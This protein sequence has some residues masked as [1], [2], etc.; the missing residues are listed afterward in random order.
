MYTCPSCWYLTRWEENFWTYDICKLC[1]REDD[2]VQLSNP[3]DWWWANLLSL[4]E[5]Q[6]LFSLSFDDSLKKDF[7]LDK[8]W[9]CLSKDELY[10]HLLNKKNGKRRVNKWFS[11][12][13]KVY[14]LN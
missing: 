6:L 3:L 14:W 13:S 10:P 1:W 7:E 8:K 9:R 2:P 11:M 12:Y 4:Y 5:N